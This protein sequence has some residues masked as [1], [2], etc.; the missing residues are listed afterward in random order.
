MPYM[1]YQ[2]CF[3]MDYRGFVV[4]SGEVD[5]P[6]V[7]MHAGPF[8]SLREAEAAAKKMNAIEATYEPVEGD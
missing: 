2:A 6:S 4:M 5:A 8:E 1:E 3:S 7:R